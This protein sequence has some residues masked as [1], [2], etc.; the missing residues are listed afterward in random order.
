MSVGTGGGSLGDDGSEDVARTSDHMEILWIR[1][2]MAWILLVFYT[3]YGLSDALFMAYNNHGQTPAVLVACFWIYKLVN[4]LVLSGTAVFAYIHLHPRRCCCC[5]R[6]YRPM[7]FAWATVSVLASVASAIPVVLD[8]PPERVAMV[9]ESLAFRLFCGFFSG[10]QVWVAFLLINAEL[11]DT[12]MRT[13]LAWWA[14]F[15]ASA[16]AIFTTGVFL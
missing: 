2:K 16:V 13:E 10:W 14:L 4:S 3:A 9:V 6:R 12:N 11:R 8:V 7:Y 1:R 15:I 5:C